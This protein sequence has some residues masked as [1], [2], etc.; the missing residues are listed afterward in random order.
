MG[1][2]NKKYLSLCTTKEIGDVC[3]QARNT[4]AFVKLAFQEKTVKVR[5][6]KV[7]IATHFAQLYKVVNKMQI[8][9]QVGHI[10]L[11]R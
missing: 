7:L 8:L 5:Q 9:M 3:T 11:V 4:C 6:N 2:T 10:I 1:F